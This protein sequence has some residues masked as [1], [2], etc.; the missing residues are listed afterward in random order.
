MQSLSFLY[1]QLTMTKIEEE[2][3]ITM[4]FNKLCS[5]VSKMKTLGE[6]VSEPMLAQIM[7]NVLP[8]TY[9]VV[10]TVIQTTNQNSTITPDIVFKSALA[11]EE[12]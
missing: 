5:I 11:E 9:T 12:Q 10:N 3:D 2:E 1:Q 6:P 4:G 7:M 8:P